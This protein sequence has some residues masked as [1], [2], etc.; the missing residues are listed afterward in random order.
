MFLNLL[1]FQI[2]LK[3]KRSTIGKNKNKK[4][5]DEKTIFPTPVNDKI[6]PDLHPYQTYNYIS[7]YCIRQKLPSDFQTAE[8]LL[9]YGQ[10]DMVFKRSELRKK[11]AKILEMHGV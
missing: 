9:K 8:Y 7:T 4:T 10:V 1:L 5:V 11:L 2:G 6:L 3:Y